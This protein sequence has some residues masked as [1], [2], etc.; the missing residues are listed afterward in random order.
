MRKDK[1]TRQG[2]VLGGGATIVHED[3]DLLVVDK[4]AGMISA[5]PDDSTGL[6]LFGRVKRYARAQQRQRGR[7]D[8]AAWV[9]HRLDRDVSGLLVF[10]KSHEAY[11][12][13]KD[14]LK[15]RQ[16]RRRYLAVVGGELPPTPAGQWK[17]ID[18][19]L[20]DAGPGRPVRL[21][22]TGDAPSAKTVGGEREPR[23]VKEPRGPMRAVTYYRVLASRDGHSLLLIGLETG[24]KHQI[25]AQLAGQG[26]PIIGDR[27]YGGTASATFLRPALHAWELGFSHPATGAA[28]RFTSPPPQEFFR[29]MG[30]TSDAILRDSAIDE[31][32]GPPGA[33]PETAPAP[34]G[35]WDHVAPWYEELVSRGRSDY[36]EELILPGVLRLLAPRA[37]QHV[38]DVACGEGLLCR[39]LAGL[40]LECVGVDASQRLIAAA[41]QAAQSLPPK[42]RASFFVGDAR[43]LEELPELAARRGSFDAAACVLALMNIDPID[44]VLLGASSMLQPGGSF[45]AVILHPAFRSPGQ[46]SW[47]WD[48]P[49]SPKPPIREGKR[50]PTPPSD[51]RQYRRVDAYL[52]STQRSIVMN[53]GQAAHGKP[54]VTT[55]TWHRPIQTYVQ[56]FAEA[57]LLVDALEEWP[58]H[59]VSEPGPR[60]AEQDRARREIPMFLAIRG[61]RL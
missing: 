4:P 34:S 25:R 40:G 41:R 54:P 42:A 22:A 21:H 37:G 59:R 53:P 11:L 23:G 45:T 12:A 57:R 26:H 52:S 2:A 48:V 36:H 51:S 14:Q 29:I 38:L 44:P 6:T 8:V 20:E 28:E 1:T 16:V 61:R 18:S 56:A 55:F 58:S 60:A 13:L 47:G 24:R 19:F 27:L 31:P 39:R 7:G 9:I 17:W 3:A 50:T 46:T 10:A 35:G 43:R 15:R 33:R 30:L 49:E 5:R 32:T